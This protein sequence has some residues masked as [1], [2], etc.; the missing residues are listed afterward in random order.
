MS[1]T[2]GQRR[3]HWLSQ[4]DAGSQWKARR[5][6]SRGPQCRPRAREV[7]RRSKGLRRP[8]EPGSALPLRPRLRSGVRPGLIREG[9][10]ARRTR[11]GD[12]L[13]VRPRRRPLASA[14]PRGAP[15][16]PRVH[17]RFSGRVSCHGDGVCPLRWLQRPLSGPRSIFHAQQNPWHTISVGRRTGEVGLGRGG[18][19]QQSVRQLGQWGSVVT[20]TATEPRWLRKTDG[21]SPEPTA[22]RGA[23]RTSQAGAVGR[24]P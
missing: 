14:P 12:E 6:R 10:R 23:P 5:R 2:E 1:G 15:F 21:V 11:G 16:A 22:A 4:E 19:G 20:E 17:R 18:A 9:Q 24:D 7:R 3:G 13:G 8:C